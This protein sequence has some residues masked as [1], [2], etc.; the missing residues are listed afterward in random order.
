MKAIF[1]F[2]FGV[3][4]TCGTLW[5]QQDMPKFP[6]DFFGN[7]KGTL[8]I[9]NSRGE[10]QIPMEFHLQATDST[11]QF[12]YTLVYGEGDARQERL[13]TLKTLD[14][15]AGT[16]VVDENNGI[17]LDDK[18]VANRM[19]SLF[20]V[21]GNLLTTFI[22]FEKDQLLF[23]IVFASKENAR[24]TYAE[25]EAKTEVI[26]YPISTVQRAILKKE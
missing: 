23:E 17:I 26:S 16:Y 8:T 12:T 22:T 3:I 11:D 19:Y 21:Q 7:Y 4:M 9:N 10:Q 24:T 14:S 13:Y 1:L 5:S 15:K 20:E 6:D 25:N 18:V 2:L